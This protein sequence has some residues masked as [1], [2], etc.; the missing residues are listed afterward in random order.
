MK[1]DVCKICLG[2][3]YYIDEDNHVNQCPVCTYYGKD[4]EPQE[5]EN[6]A[7]TETLYSSGS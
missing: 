4:D 7:R 1:E 3:D 2:N 5:L 6:E